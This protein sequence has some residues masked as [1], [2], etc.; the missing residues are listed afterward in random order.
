[1]ARYAVWLTVLVRGRRRQPALCFTRTQIP[2]GVGYADGM[3]MTTKDHLTQTL[4]KSKSP[5][6]EHRA[7]S[8]QKGNQYAR[9]TT[10]VQL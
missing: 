1:M 3:S 10:A 7:L 5:V 6:R 2:A 9:D 8:F 4:I